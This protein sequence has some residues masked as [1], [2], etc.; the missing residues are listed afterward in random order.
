MYKIFAIT[1]RGLETVCAE[2]IQT[3]P[4]V[5]VDQLGYRRVSAT[6]VGPLVPLLGL[7]TVDDVFLDVAVWYGIGRPRSTLEVLGELSAQL[8]L[9]QSLA[10]C[11]QVRAIPN[12]PAF[13]I[14]VSFVGKRNYNVH[15]VKQVCGASIELS[16][17][18]SYTN[19]DAKA[20]LNLRLFIEHETAYVGVRL[21]GRALHR[22]LYKQ[23]HTPGSLKPSV[24]AALLHMAG[25]QPGD[26]LLDPCCGAGTIL[27][28]AALSGM[29]PLGGDNDLNALAAT[30]TNA[31][32]AETAFPVTIWDAQRLPVVNG[33]V[34]R[35][36]SNLPWGRQAEVDTELGDLYKS[37]C[38]ELRRVLAAQGKVALL[39]NAPHLVDFPELEPEKHVEI[40][41]F[42]Q[43]PTILVFQDT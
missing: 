25:I 26:R 32:A 34:N 19:N 2:E 11:G 21:A 40:S 39:T 6:S 38:R 9:Y 37:A 5:T 30:C 7:R 43:T 22:R 4:G 41:L 20:Y 13:S 31:R 3:L 35:I 36:V 29:L 27:I 14:T 23:A 42:G 16:H 33:S 1:T 18:W 15:E 8:N 24:A 28:E 10:V 12:S 17:G